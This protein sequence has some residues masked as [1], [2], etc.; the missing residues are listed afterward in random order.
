MVKLEKKKG[1]PLSFFKITLFIGITISISL[2]FISLYL[3]ESIESDS[4]I[5]TKFP[6]VQIDE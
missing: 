6:S 5:A 1:K 2:T 3:K 4:G